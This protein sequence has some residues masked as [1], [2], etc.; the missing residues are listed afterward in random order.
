ME[1]WDASELQENSLPSEPPGN[2]IPNASTEALCAPATIS[3]FIQTK[4]LF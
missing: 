4:F 3:I 2:V 1:V